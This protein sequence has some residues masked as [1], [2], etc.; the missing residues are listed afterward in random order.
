MKAVLKLWQLTHNAA[1][2][3]NMARLAYTDLSIYY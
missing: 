2:G 1:N 3:G